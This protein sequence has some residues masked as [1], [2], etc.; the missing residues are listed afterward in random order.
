MTSTAAPTPPA[1]RIV[2]CPSCGGPS[3]Y[4]ASNTYRPFCS[5]RCRLQDLSAWASEQYAVEARPGLEGESDDGESSAPPPR[6]G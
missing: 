4:A 2:R 3:V 1:P 6:S 5:A